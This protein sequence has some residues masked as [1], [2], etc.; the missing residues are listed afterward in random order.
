MKIRRLLP[1]LLLPLL[2]LF[3]GCSGS[4]GAQDQSG[5]G[6]GG[7]IAAGLIDPQN[8]LAYLG[9]FRLPEGAG[10][11]ESWDWAGGGMTYYPGG[12]TDGLPGSLFAVGNGVADLISEISI[13]TPVNSRDLE[14]LNTAAIRQAFADVRGGMFQSLIDSGVP[15]VAIQY[16]DHPTIGRKIHMAWGANLQ[17][18]GGDADVASHGWFDIDLGDPDPQGAWRIGSQSLYSVND[19]MFEIPAAWADEHVGGRYLATGR[20]KDGGMGG[21]GPALFAYGPWLGGNPPANNAVLA[22]QILLLYGKTTEGGEESYTQNAL[23]D[24]SCADEWRGG[25]WLES[26]GGNTAVVMAGTKSTGDYYWYGYVD[27]DSPTTPCIEEDELSFITCRTADGQ[28]CLA[29]YPNECVNRRTGKGWR[30][31]RYDAQFIFYD[32][33]DLAG[34]AAGTMGSHEPQPY[35]TLDIDEELF[36]SDLTAD[37]VETIGS[38][39]QRKYR[40]NAVAYDRANNYLYVME[41]FADGARPVIHV[42][43]VIN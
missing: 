18:E 10:A 1:S 6:G 34:V 12:A 29:E 16:L 13:P 8:D 37:V 30:A 20:F 11:E 39:E 2:F 25:A 31:S 32:P 43:Q 27:G 42:W 38:G 14:D 33:A 24:Y 22:E 7:E 9:A 5:E 41:P 26:E 36:L 3:S 15:E 40:V 17:D 21:K 19:Y 23:E 4:S 28:S 35:A